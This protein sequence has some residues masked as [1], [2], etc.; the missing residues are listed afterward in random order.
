[1]ITE[2]RASCFI[3]IYLPIYLKISIETNSMGSFKLPCSYVLI[4]CLY[5]PLVLTSQYRLSSVS[6][7]P[8]LHLDSAR[9]QNRVTLKH[10]IET[11]LQA[12]LSSVT[13]LPCKVKGSRPDTLL[14]LMLRLL[15]LSGVRPEATQNQPSTGFLQ[16]AN[17]CP[18]P[19]GRWFT[20]TGR[21][22]SSSAR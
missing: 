22:T 15:F 11:N 7:L 6:L 19:P 9:H 14:C 5:L 21:W 13:S 1:M 17:W 16:R 8:A 12:T 3:R 4:F 20:I 2:I 10:S 18:T